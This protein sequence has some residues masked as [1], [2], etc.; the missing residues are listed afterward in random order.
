M[1][2]PW[3]LRVDSSRARRASRR[4]SP[5]RPKS[6]VPRDAAAL[7]SSATH[8]AFGERRDIVTLRAGRAIARFD[9]SGLHDPVDSPGLGLEEVDVQ[10]GVGGNP[11]VADVTPASIR[12]V[13]CS[14][15][16][17]KSSKA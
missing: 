15:A 11:L 1:L 16:P 8:C 5:E 9:L 2:S 4:A 14:G 7:S 6:K 3:M 10:E 13:P 17:S 12:N